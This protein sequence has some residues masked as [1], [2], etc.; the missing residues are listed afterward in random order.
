M[1]KKVKMTMILINKLKIIQKLKLKKKQNQTTD[2][3]NGK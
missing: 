2:E 1:I 3:E